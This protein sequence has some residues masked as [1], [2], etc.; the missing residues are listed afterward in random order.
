MFYKH[1][2]KD[3]QDYSI[4]F[5]TIVNGT[6]FLISFSD[7]LLLVHRNTN[8]FCMLILHLIL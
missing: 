7:S 5:D 4:I 8:N 1:V 3:R 6:V 2:I